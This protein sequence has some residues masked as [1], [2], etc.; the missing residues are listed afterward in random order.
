M[1]GERRDLNGV[2]VQVA[3]RGLIQL[4]G[5]HADGVALDRVERQTG[6]REAGRRQR[7]IGGVNLIGRRRC[8]LSAPS[9]LAATDMFW[10][11]SVGM[12][13]WMLFRPGMTTSPMLIGPKLSVPEIVGVADIDIRDPV[14][15]ADVNV[16]VDRDVDVT[17]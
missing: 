12:C 17:S 10:A 15:H 2:A 14:G 8:A 3:D 11:V 13:R 5:R 1:S 7:D 16:P 9:G 4:R 6:D